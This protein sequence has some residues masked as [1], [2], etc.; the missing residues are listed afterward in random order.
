MTYFEE[1]YLNKIE[2]GEFYD[3]VYRIGGLFIAILTNLITE[4]GNFSAFMISLI[5]VN[6]FKKMNKELHEVTCIFDTMVIN[7]S[8]ET[9]INDN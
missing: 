7:Q 5:L 4:N 9:T 3:Y 2:I 6:F 8:I 1:S